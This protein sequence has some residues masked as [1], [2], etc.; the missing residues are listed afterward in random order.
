MN[1]LGRNQ[2]PDWEHVDKYP[3]RAIAQVPEPTEEGEPELKDL[4]PTNVPVAF[5]INWYDSFDTPSQDS[6][7]NWVIRLNGSIRGGHCVCLEPVPD[8]NEKGQEQDPKTAWWPFYNQGQEGSC[9][10]HGVSRAQGLVYRRRFDAVWLYNEARK[11]DGDPDPNHEGTTVRAGLEVLRQQGHRV[12]HGD[13]TTDLKKSDPP[14]PR[15]G[16]SAYRWATTAEEVL[17]A[18]GYPSDALLV[19]FLNSWGEDYPHVCHFHIDDIAR[20]LS[21]AGEAGVATDR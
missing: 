18:L 10:G 6:A 17:A 5:G 20:L 13:V 12:A 9:V 19:P 2:P 14:N 3:L 7:G 11:I 16:V 1:A 21:E 8:P 15:Y 4:R